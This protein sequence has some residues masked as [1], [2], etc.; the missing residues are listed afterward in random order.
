MGTVLLAV[1]ELRGIKLQYG[2]TKAKPEGDVLKAKIIT[3]GQLIIDFPF[4]AVF[5]APS[6]SIQ[7]HADQYSTLM[8][9]LAGVGKVTISRSTATIHQSGVAMVSRTLN[10]SAIHLNITGMIDQQKELKKCQT[11][12]KKLL[13]NVSQLET[14][15]KAPAYSKSAPAH[16][17]EAHSKKIVAM[18]N[19]ISQL[20]DYANMFMKLYK[21]TTY[22]LSFF[23]D[24]YLIIKV[25][26]RIKL[27]FK[28]K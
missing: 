18:R 5:V 22:I 11:K 6:E 15:M 20:E 12:L 23:V 8:S 13:E 19:E 17:Q 14:T 4:I 27:F 25:V 2:L 10:N 1:A 26:P 3:W 16:I 24:D 7:R 9:T 28:F 21:Y